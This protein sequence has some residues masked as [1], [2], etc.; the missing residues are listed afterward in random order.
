MFLID[1]LDAEVGEIS[2]ETLRVKLSTAEEE[3]VILHTKLKEEKVGE[4]SSKH[5]TLPIHNAI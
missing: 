2:N 1:N 3:I 5:L 4:S